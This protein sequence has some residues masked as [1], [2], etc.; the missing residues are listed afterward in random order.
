MEKINYKNIPNCLRKYR[1]VRG[2]KQHEVA[3]I[4]GLKSASLISRWE[5]SGCIPDTVN[6]FRLSILYRTMADA[7]FIDLVRR[8][9]PEL[10]K[11]E[12][13]LLKKSN[14]RD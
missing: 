3:V 13:M 12:E 1:R 5:N 10:L 9:K 4:L 11:R 2:L 14:D 7:L 8:L 6:V